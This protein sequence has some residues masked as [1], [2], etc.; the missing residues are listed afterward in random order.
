M[1]SK[2]FFQISLR[3]P[4]DL[5]ERVREVAKAERRSMTAQVVIILEDWLA[6]Q[7]EAAE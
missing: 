7:T 2:D 5:V 3:V 6:E 4:V 1:A